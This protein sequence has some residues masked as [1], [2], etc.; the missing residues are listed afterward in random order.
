MNRIKWLLLKL[1]LFAAAFVALVAFSQNRYQL[2]EL[3]TVDINIDYGSGYYFVT[4]KSIQDDLKSTHR[5][6]PNL[7]LKRLSLHTMEEKI[8]SNPFIDSV[9]IY[10]ENNGVLK[11]NI[12]QQKPVLRLKNGG[13]EFYLNELGEELPLSSIYSAPV[14]LVTGPVEKS[15]FADLSALIIAINEDNLLKNI[16][17]GVS[18]TNVN[19]FI[20]FTVDDSYTVELGDLK[21]INQKFE[22]FKAFYHSLIANHDQLPYNYINIS[23]NNQIVASK[24]YE[25]KK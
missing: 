11:A 5:D 15:E 12:I 2:R 9:E 18:K 25:Y 21:N 23:F 8:W 24:S 1:V 20:L 7:A 13:K 19:S 3:E 16:V 17:T 10:L 4:E 22:N 14:F 6:F